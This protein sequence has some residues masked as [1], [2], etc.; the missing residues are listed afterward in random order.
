[1]IRSSPGCKS[2]GGEP[3]LGASC[4]AELRSPGTFSNSSQRGRIV[5]TSSTNR[6]ERLPRAPS[7]PARWPATEKSWQGAP[8]TRRSIGPYWPVRS[9]KSSAFTSPRFGSSGRWPL[10]TEHGKGSISAHH[11]QSTHGIAVSG[12]K[13]PLNI[14]DPV[15]HRCP[16][17]QCGISTLCSE[18]STPEVLPLIC[19]FP[20]CLP[21]SPY[22]AFRYTSTATA[23][24]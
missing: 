16:G 5:L 2:S 11:F 4:E 10:I 1:M 19:H 6:R 21:N 18:P 17:F 3:A 15:R 12:A 8:A 9:A 7:I 22:F 13:I 24:I 23:A 20:R 14:V